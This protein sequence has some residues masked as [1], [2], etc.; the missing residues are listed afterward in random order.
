MLSFE[1]NKKEFMERILRQLTAL[2]EGLNIHI[3]GGTRTRTP[4]SRKPW[5]CSPA[6]G[7]RLTNR[8][9]STVPRAVAPG[10]QMQD[11]VRV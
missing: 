7:I 6:L 2:K 8:D 5:A 4:L 9:A 1:I 10:I 11:P 3:L